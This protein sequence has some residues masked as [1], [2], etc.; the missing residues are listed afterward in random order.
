I[1]IDDALIR[2][3]LDAAVRARA[4]AR[5]GKL[6]PPLVE[7]S[8]CNG[9][10]LAGICLPD[11]VNLLK[12]LSRAATENASSVSEEGTESEPKEGPRLRTLVLRDERNPLYV[13]DQ[14]AYVRLDG[15][16]LVVRP[17]EGESREVRIP[18]T[19]HVAVFGNVQ[20]TAQAMRTLI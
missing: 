1:A 19:S 3:T 11:E 5:A 6:P 20:V 12:T 17:R 4:L 2:T 8:K 14:G 7:S 10:S 13:T 16:C 9:C 18:H 15:E